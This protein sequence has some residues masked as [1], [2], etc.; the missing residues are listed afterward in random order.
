MAKNVLINK[1]IL[2]P[3]VTK[4][5]YLLKNEKGQVTI[6]FAVAIV[7][8]ITLIS[9]VVNVGLFVK[10]KINLQNATDAAAWSGAATQARQLTDIAYMN[11]EMRNV[12]KQWM[13]KY[14]VL[15]N[16]SA[17]GVRTPG[18]AG[19]ENDVTGSREIMDFTIGPRDSK[20]KFNIPSVC[21]HPRTNLSG[22]NL[23]GDICSVYTIPG[24]PRLT[25]GFTSIDQTTSALTDAL[26][27]EKAN[28]CAARSKANFN[29]ALAW[30]YGTGSQEHDQK[31]LETAPHVATN[32]TGAWVKATELAH[33]I[34]NMEFIVNTPPQSNVGYSEV[35]NLQ[36][37]N[38]VGFERT[39]K[40][41][42]SAY[43][44]LGNDSTDSS[45]KNS[46][47]LTELAPEVKI[48]NN[49]ASLS[50]LFIPSSS[51]GN[52]KYY[53]D[54]KIMPIN[55]VN[56]FTALIPLATQTTATEIAREAGCEVSKIAIPVP[57]YPLGFTKNPEVMTYYAIKTEAQFSGLFN[58]IGQSIRLTAY[59][60]AK[61]F[62]GRIGP[63]LFNNYRSDA[64]NSLFARSD[65][66]QRSLPY[67]LGLNLS[68][69]LIPGPQNP[70]RPAIVPVDNSLWVSSPEDVIGGSTDN[71]ASLKYVVPNL[72]Y[73]STRI[74]TV[75]NSPFFIY[76]LPAAAGENVP[77]K[78]GL[79]DKNEFLKF[80]GNLASTSGV[81]EPEAVE[82]A[83]KN[84][85]KPTAYENQN[86]LIPTSESA[87][88]SSLHLDTFG[89][90]KISPN[91]NRVLIYAPLYGD[92]L[93]Y[94][95]PMLI[96]DSVKLFL[97]T[98]RATIDVFVKNLFDV[99]TQI[100]NIRP[101]TPNTTIDLYKNAADFFYN[102]AVDNAGNLNCSS[103]AGQFL[104]YFFD[105]ESGINKD[106]SCDGLSTLPLAL[107]EIYS[108]V[109]A[110]AQIDRNHYFLE[111]FYE[112]TQTQKYFTA[113]A[114]G[115]LSGAD[116][117]NNPEMLGTITNPFLSTSTQSL[118]NFYSTKL[119]S[120]QSLLAT[121]EQ[122]FGQNIPLM[123]EGSLGDFTGQTTLLNPLNQ[124]QISNDV[125]Q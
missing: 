102:S 115:K 103:M 45:F 62:G 32:H 27:R 105:N 7:V 93:L 56:F 38:H 100:R 14:Y 37:Q 35:E 65:S 72:I 30:I 21:I 90:G 71:T 121:S 106:A 4:R 3:L 55:F 11:W 52:E 114:P 116:E 6:F 120:L 46:F 60:A 85:K 99:S 101:T 31:I 88:N 63:T 91:D 110:G 59:A 113:Y 58:P 73:D 26:S 125:F 98:Q 18:A 54:L 64:T 33:R 34:R 20:D 66:K 9:F 112:G 78:L 57:G 24:L 84:V 28:D 124:D 118:R 108:N 53:L 51:T 25:F 70:G 76:N 82:I 95:T 68:P 123:S 50:N 36:G 47:K 17:K 74:E 41:F 122:S 83:L 97:R 23:Q 44:N 119:V 77:Y 87:I 111:L 69:S 10:A 117:T 15:G 8:I 49:Q 96:L 67:A 39:I 16:L 13:F 80:S 86:Y 43:R 29:I 104:Y 109:A 48:D 1:D 42:Y 22:N 75:L 12:Y 5:S 107:E 92:N 79:Y 61:P 94:Q 2:A 81:I 40:A 19:N 89:L